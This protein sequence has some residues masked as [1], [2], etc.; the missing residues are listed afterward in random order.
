MLQGGQKQ[1][2]PQD[3][4]DEQFFRMVSMHFTLRL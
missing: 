3:E 2:C 4:D 1:S